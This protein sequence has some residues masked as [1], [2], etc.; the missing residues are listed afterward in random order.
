M[1]LRKI[2]NKQQ[3]RCNITVK[4]YTNVAPV[5]D[6]RYGEPHKRSSCF[7]QK[8]SIYTVEEV[9]EMHFGLQLHK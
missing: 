4:F 9:T 2:Q 1:Q 7:K 8:I 3:K 6:D 5:E